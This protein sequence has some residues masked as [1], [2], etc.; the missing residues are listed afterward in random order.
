MSGDVVIQ[1]EGLGKKYVIEHQADQES[2][3]SL[4][5]LIVRGAERLARAIRKPGFQG[6]G[7]RTAPEDFW[8]LRDVDFSIHQ[9]EVV[10]VVGRNGAGKSTLLKVLSRITEPSRGRVT[11]KG[12]LASL[13]E[14]GT[15]F[16][17]ELTGR[18]NIFLNGAILGM[19]RF[20][21]RRKFDEIV[22]FAEIE[23]FLDTPVKRYSSG[24]YVRLAFAVA[25]HLEPDIL[26]VDE[27]LAVGDAAF[28][29]KSLGKMSDFSRSGM[30]VLLVSHNMGLVRQV[31]DRGILLDAG[32]VVIDGSCTEAVNTYLQGGIGQTGG[33]IWR[34]ADT[35]S[36]GVAITGLI[37]MSGDGTPMSKFI[38]GEAVRIDMETNFVRPVAHPQFGLSVHSSDGTPIL[39]LRTRHSG[40]DIPVASGAVDFSVAI[41]EFS[42]FP[43]DYILSA[44]VTDA[45][46]KVLDWLEY[47]IP[48]TV[49]SRPGPFGDM[50]L[51]LT[52]GKYYVRSNWSL[53]SSA[54][55][56]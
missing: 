33:P 43:G 41:A 44:W 5:D 40:P 21:T 14:V 55:M 20:E 25:A 36:D 49:L 28:Q 38:I 52:Q 32:R 1:A 6:G 18:E 31:C 35:Q 17:P 51:S 54:G 11:V 2:Y 24:M 34:R 48:F 23:R 22:A 8:A 56:A 26:V 42:L 10:G 30:T 19:S 39:D 13:L 37:L 29:K 4:R 45:D 9:G 16:H 12:R 46:S 15:G 50:R 27:V 47:C 7:E 53:R 3:R